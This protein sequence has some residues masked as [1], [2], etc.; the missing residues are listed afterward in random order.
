MSGYGEGVFAKA[1]TGVAGA[2]FNPERRLTL[3]RRCSEGAG[4]AGREQRLWAALG[5]CG[6]EQRL[7]GLNRADTGDADDKVKGEV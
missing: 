4:G 2:R 1:G 3:A 6:P 5:T 7:Q